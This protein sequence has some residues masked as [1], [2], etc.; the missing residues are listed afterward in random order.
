[1]THWQ[2]LLDRAIFAWLRAEREGR[3]DDVY[4]NPARPSDWTLGQQ[5]AEDIAR[6]RQELDDSRKLSQKKYYNSCTE[7]VSESVSI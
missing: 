7:G 5:L 4:R 6:Y 1:M 3:L 2:A